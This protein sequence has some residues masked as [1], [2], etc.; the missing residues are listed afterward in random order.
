MACLQALTWLVQAEHGWDTLY[1][2]AGLNMA[3]ADQK[4]PT[5][6]IHCS[7]LVQHNAMCYLGHF[8]IASVCGKRHKQSYQDQLALPSRLTHERLWSGSWSERGSCRRSR[9][10]GRS[11]IQS[12]IGSRSQSRTPGG[13]GGAGVRSAHTYLTPVIN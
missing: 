3:T 4:E 9:V 12:W 8:I 5:K 6:L 7:E 11:E 10:G 13:E 2:S 1:M